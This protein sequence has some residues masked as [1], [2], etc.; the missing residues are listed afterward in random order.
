MTKKKNLII[1]LVAITAI[2]GV[3]F[4]YI[5]K[6]NDN[7]SD[8]GGITTMLSTD[9]LKDSRSVI[10]NNFAYLENN[11]LDNADMSGG[12]GITYTA[13]GTYSFDCSE[14][15]G[16][17]INCSSEDITLD[18]TGDWTGTLDGYE[19][20][21]LVGGGS[22]DYLGSIGDVSTT[23][24]TA[25]YV[26]KYSGTEW[27]SVATSTLGLG[28]TGSMTYPDAGIALSAGSAWDTSI[29]NNSANWN[30][31]Y[32]WGNWATQG[33]E[34][35]A[36]ASSSFS[37]LTHD[38]S[39]L[40]DILGQATS[41]LAS[42]T[43]AYNHDN[44]LVNGSIDTIA[45]LNAIL[46]GE[47][48]ASTSGT[49][50]NLTAGA[51][52]ALA[53]DPT[54]CSTGQFAIAIAANG[55]LTCAATSTFGNMNALSDN[56]WTLHNDYPS[57]CSA[58]QYV[59]AIGDTL[60]CGTPAGTGS[61][62]GVWA[63]SSATQLYVNDYNVGIGTS[64]PRWDL[65]IA[66]SGYPYLILSDETMSSTTVD[67][68]LDLDV[69]LDNLY[70]SNKYGGFEV[71][72][73]ENATNKKSPL[74][75][76][77]PTID[78]TGTISKGGT[79][80][81]G[82]LAGYNL[83]ATS[84]FLDSPNILI[85]E[86][87]GFSMKDYGH[88]S[89][90]VGFGA[91]Y[92]IAVGK[93][94]LAECEY[95]NENIVIGNNA[96]KNSVGSSTVSAYSSANTLVGH[97]ILA[98]ANSTTSAADKLWF[99][100]AFGNYALSRSRDSDANAMFGAY[101]GNK[102]SGN[103]NVGV[104]NYSLYSY[105]NNYEIANLVNNNVGVGYMAGYNLAEST[106]NIL[107]GYKAGDNLATSSQ[108]IIIGYD[109]DGTSTTMTKGLNIG[110][111]IFGNGID[112]TGTTLSSGKIGI[113]TS[114]PAYKLDV[115]GT[116][117]LT[118]S[119]TIGL[120]TITPNAS[121]NGNVLV[122]D[123]TNAYWQATST[124]GL[125]GG[126]SGTVTSVDMSVPTGLSISG[127]PITGAGTLAVSLTGGYIIPL[128]AS[129]TAWNNFLNTPSGVIT[130]GDGIDW[131]TNTLNV[132]NVTAP[133]LASA[134]F[135]DFTCNG[136]TCS[137]DASYLVAGSIDTIAE[138]NA[139]LTGEDV[140]STSGS[141]TGNAG[142]AT[143]LASNPTACSAGQYVSDI[144]ANGTLTCG[145]PASGGAGVGWAT[146]SATQLYSTIASVGI[147]TTTPYGNLNISSLS[148]PKLVLSNQEALENRK[149]WAITASSTSSE[150]T[151]L[152]IFR[153]NDDLSLGIIALS[154]GDALHENTSIDEYALSSLT[155]G[156][157]NV[158]LGR[159]SL[160]SDTTG[161]Y[162]MAIGAGS[163]NLNTTGSRNIAI[164]KSAMTYVGS[165]T[166]TVAIGYLAGMG[167][168]G[169]SYYQNN[170]LIGYQSGKGLTTGDSNILIGYNSGDALLSGDNNIVIGYDIDVPA[171]TTNGQMTIGNLIYATGLSATNTTIS[172]GLVGIA[173]NT[174]AYTLDVYG[175]VSL[176]GNAGAVTVTA[177]GV[178]AFTGTGGLTVPN[179]ATCNLNGVAGRTC[180][181][182]S[183]GQLQ[184]FNSATSTFIA[185]QPASFSYATSTAWTGTTTIPL[186]VAWEAETWTGI[187]C[188]TDAG[189]L[190][191]SVYDGTNRMNIY[192]GASTTVS[193]MVL[194]TNNTF[195]ALE[196]RYVDIGNPATAPTKI[197]C[198]IKKA[199]D[200]N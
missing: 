154:V 146:S 167:T 59:S 11:K 142:T 64:T 111:I 129:T 108:N 2:A 28:G 103:F 176:G 106:G 80:A 165:A 153:L 88:T 141:I 48:V 70:I 16:T 24:L 187:A 156:S 160:R 128:S 36:Q 73:I 72:N 79:I 149:H 157:Y 191:V 8:L 60:T 18:A 193:S 40:Y 14:V 84:T 38:H 124:L 62:D 137:L 23:S 89:Y 198:T 170:T 69:P 114:S 83:T 163:M 67:A 37:L 171:S 82:Q 25:G 194:S 12:E 175:T 183:T 189:T 169:Q 90:T 120:T 55:N 185:Y 192:K 196:K 166:N 27:E 109:I 118:G 46:T 140:A 110:N 184:V 45:E 186:G 178:L 68:L 155:T 161:G 95:C 122:S 61:G 21:A 195:T 39:T 181:D 150:Y 9:T 75:N 174:P 117:R 19:A 66:S 93:Y 119:T 168:S 44:F 35:Q 78:H 86:G 188:F 13:T 10:N 123:G 180:F 51:A 136:T 92:N 34:T 56:T 15:E 33:F 96:L 49:Y 63:T 50:A 164:G 159:D 53:A 77:H 91:Y 7:L 162:N 135:G 143:A 5:S 105:Y 47:D 98:Y 139:I 43:T 3:A 115:Y 107:L 20:S 29:V 87:S 100:T 65:Q 177:G 6:P 125:G 172:T 42:H 144:D 133:M 151:G 102:L 134:D 32:G 179:S 127:N 76:I 58:G 101:S 31:A 74:I 173:T 199:I 113:G 71:G 94:S 158:A 145:T 130:A 147:G 152:Q 97:E 26:L 85:G 52:T 17:G 197:S 200:P 57:A 131:S 138:L 132:D 126:G 4:Y 182:T 99:N 22:T 148:H 54:D 190:D 41:T 116:G 1:G 30:T 81:I 112:G 121:V 104:G